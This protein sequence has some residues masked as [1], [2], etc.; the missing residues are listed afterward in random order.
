MP[1][2]PLIQFL[3]AGTNLFTHHGY[4]ELYIEGRWVKAT[5]TMDLKM[6]QEEGI[7]PVEFDGKNYRP[8][9]YKTKERY[10]IISFLPHADHFYR[11][12]LKPLE[13]IRITREY[14]DFIL[15][16]SKLIDHGNSKGYYDIDG[17]KVEIII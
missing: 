1:Q 14:F 11:Y 8:T 4:D 15:A 13:S 16:N 10:L 12:R 7:I 2:Q 5:P 6:C 9:S 17:R 3:S